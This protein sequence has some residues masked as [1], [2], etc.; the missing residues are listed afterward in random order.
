M[1][2]ESSPCILLLSLC[3]GGSHRATSCWLNCDSNM[4]RSCHLE[5]S[6]TATAPVKARHRTGSSGSA[7][8]RQA[9]CPWVP[10]LMASPYNCC[11]TGCLC[12]RTSS[13]TSHLDDLVDRMRRT[14]FVTG[15]LVLGASSILAGSCLRRW[16]VH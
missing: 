4:S 16:L 3:P 14:C 2:P 10:I 5:P 9:N 1:I 8:T 7:P 6:D 11:F 15:L 13:T 12:V